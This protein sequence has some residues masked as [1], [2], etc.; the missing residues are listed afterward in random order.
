MDNSIPGNG[1][2]DSDVHGFADDHDRRTRYDHW[3]G[4]IH[5]LK[6]WE[7]HGRFSETETNRATKLTWA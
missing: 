6:F 4:Q 7:D 2:S 3:I 5:I 1:E